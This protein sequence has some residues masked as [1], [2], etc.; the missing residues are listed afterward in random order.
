MIIKFLLTIPRLPSFEGSACW[1]MLSMPNLRMPSLISAKSV[2]LDVWNSS[3]TNSESEILCETDFLSPS[4]LDTSAALGSTTGFGCSETAD[5]V[6][7][8]SGFISVLVELAFWSVLFSSDFL[9][10]TDLTQFNSSQLSCCIYFII[11][12]K[13]KVYK[14][15]KHE[16]KKE[17]YKYKSSNL[18]R[19]K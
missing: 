13:N 14:K 15:R 4:S 9:G 7:R 1:V 11:F 12:T 16:K 2:S 5:M 3:E 17:K 8:D 19:N 10:L 18:T 6:A